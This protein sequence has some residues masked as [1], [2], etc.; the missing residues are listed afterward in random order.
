MKSIKMF[1]FLPLL[2][3][4]IHS[5]AETILGSSQDDKVLVSFLGQNTNADAIID[6]LNQY[7]TI[8]I[9]APTWPASLNTNKA[10]IIDATGSNDAAQ[11]RA[12]SIQYCQTNIAV[13]ETAYVFP[14]GYSGTW[15]NKNAVLYC[16][17]GAQV[18]VG[19]TNGTITV[20]GR[21]TVRALQGNLGYYD[22]ECYTFTGFN[23]ALQ[24]TCSVHC[25]NATLE[26]AFSGEGATVTT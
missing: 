6:G 1:I 14:G 2:L 25:V 21:G 7:G 16:A 11:R 9:K 15:T 5:H 10:W 8:P 4:G 23:N 13:G 22:I 20:R 24:T 18:N 12:A 26:C 19:A 17:E 3:T